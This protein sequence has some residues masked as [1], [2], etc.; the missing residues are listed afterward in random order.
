MIEQLQSLGQSIENIN[1]LAAERARGELSAA[2]YHSGRSSSDKPILAI[3]G[4]TGTGKSTVINRLLGA[5]ITATSFKRTYTAG[6]VV[7]TSDAIP[8]QFAAMPHV[9]ADSRPA[10]GKTDRITIIRSSETILEKYILIDTPDIDGELT[11]HH[12][13]AD[14][15]FRWSDAVIFL[16]SPEKYQMPELQ[17]YYRLAMRYG[18]PSRYVMN[19]ADSAEMVADYRN[20][21]QRSNIVNAEVIAIPRDDST[22]QP[23]NA[24]RFSADK[25]PAIPAESNDAGFE[26]RVADI[27]SRINDQLLQPMIDQRSRVDKTILNLTAIAGS[28]VDVDVHPI[29]DQLQKRLREKSV[30]YLMGPQRILDRVRS[31]PS[32]LARLPRGMWDWTRTGEFKMPGINPSAKP[33]APDFRSIVI[34]QFTSLQSRI[35]DLVKNTAMLKTEAPD[36][37]L[38]TESAGEIVDSE[39]ENLKTWLETRWNATPRDTAILQRLLKVIPGAEKIT[40]YSE[41]APY[42]LA[43]AC[44]AHGAVFGH[45]DLLV[46]GG[47]SAFTWLSERLSNE[48]ATRTKAANHAIADRYDQLANQQIDRAIVWLNDSVPEHDQLDEISNQ[49]QRL[50]R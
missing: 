47:Y 15:I 11:E 36:W 29:T 23:D 3:I 21:L 9:D 31:V 35:D 39:L 10:K 40:A 32:M 46:L 22:W 14:R 4:G 12:G 34:E 26:A 19:K 18:I 38:P 25:L 5:E 45:L 6:P 44:V 13:L 30:L 33:E 24:Q 43:I 7:I 28:M 8:S 42:L 17:P 41:A 16:V 49:L 2:V 1:T 48:V 27:T 37:K 50:R 20:L